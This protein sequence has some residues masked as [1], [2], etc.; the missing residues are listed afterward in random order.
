MSDF[1]DIPRARRDDP[2]TSRLAAEGLSTA[3]SHC[4]A[5][6]FQAYRIAQDGNVFTDE[7][8]AERAG[9]RVQGICWWH[10]CSDLRSLGLI[11]WVHN[12]DGSQRKVLGS[13][14]RL[15]GVSRIT[16]AGR[17]RVETARAATG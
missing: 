5:I 4:L 2:E 15:V 16:E 7:A 17:Q 12:R 9:L 11:A 1:D 14:G 8:V 6:L 10:R 3:E 13:N